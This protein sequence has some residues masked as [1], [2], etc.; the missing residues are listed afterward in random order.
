MTATSVN[1]LKKARLQ[2]L[3]LVANT[4]TI[5]A[6]TK[7]TNISGGAPGTIP[8]QTAVNTTTQ[9]AA[10]TSGYLLKA[11]GAAAPSWVNPKEMLA[12]TDLSDVAITTPASGQVLSFNGSAGVNSAIPAATATTYGGAKFSL[13]GT[14][15]TITV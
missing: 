2:N 11:N 1:T 6:S 7:A 9:L 12:V 5:S 8:Y 4:D 10:G 3:G 14:T 13:S 15:L